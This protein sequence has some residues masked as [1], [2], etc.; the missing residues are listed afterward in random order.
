MTCSNSLHLCLTSHRFSW[1]STICENIGLLTETSARIIYSS[2]VMV[3]SNSVGDRLL[4]FTTTY[5][6]ETISA[7]F[8][9]AIQV[10]SEG[11]QCSDVVGVVYW[12]VCCSTQ[13]NTQCLLCSLQAPEM[14]TYVYFSYLC[15]MLNTSTGDHMTRSKL[16]FGR[17][18]PPFGKWPRLSRPSQ[19]I[20]SSP[21]VGRP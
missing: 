21:P 1:H 9:N 7:D 10:P 3:S 5:S 6:F 19:P 16:I 13:V 11:S 2:T 12:Q 4:T 8:T 20:S 14:R 17:S 18:V 15:H